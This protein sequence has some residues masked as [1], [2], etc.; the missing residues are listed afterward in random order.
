MNKEF[1]IVATEDEFIVKPTGLSRHRP[2]LHPTEAS[3]RYTEDGRSMVAGTCIRASWYRSM[4]ASRNPPSVSLAHKA[5]LGKWDETGLIDRWKRMGIWYDNNI[6]FYQKS[7]FL[8]GEMDAVIINPFTKGLIGI[9]VKTF[10]DYYANKEIRGAKQAKIP[11]VPK[12]NHFLQASLYAW[13]YKDILEEFRIYY[14]ERGSGVRVEFRVGSDVE[15]DGKH[16]MWW[17]QIES[18]NW[19][20]FIPNKVYQLYTVE[21][22]YSRFNELISALNKKELPQKDYLPVWDD[23]TIEWMWTH[24]KLGKTK[25][26]AW[27]KKPK[28]NPITDWHCD[29][30]NYS[31]Q[32]KQDELTNK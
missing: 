6:K 2:G 18:K 22:V 15:P 1:S 27:E 5:V 14:L 29:Y 28:A 23:E 24:G 10:Y 26:T 31:N 17:Q 16:R 32:C 25:Y 11:G 30:C 3:V 20:Y 12:D 19:N 8:S 21:D 13:E 4:E 9:E 7:H